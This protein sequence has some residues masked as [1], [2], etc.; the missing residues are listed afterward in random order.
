M[1]R[2]CN[3]CYNNSCNG[4]CNRS[5]TRQIRVQNNSIGRDG[6]DGF[7]SSKII[8]YSRSDTQPSA[9]NS[10][11]T[12]NFLTG[13]ITGIPSQWS[14]E[15]VEDNGMPLWVTSYQLISNYDI[16]YI[17][18]NNWIEPKVLVRSGVDGAGIVIKGKLDSYEELLEIE[19]PQIGDSYSVKSSIE[20][21]PALLYT[22]GENGWPLEGD[23]I[24]IQGRDGDVYIPE[25]T[26]DYFDL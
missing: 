25:E 15:E 3:K 7:N 17:Y 6:K 24:P 11:I 1:I 2:K 21:D 20:G 8:L 18:P 14:S 5:V 4:S 9:P 26:N 10:V 23:G 16:D 22:Y 19:N 12:Y 13:S